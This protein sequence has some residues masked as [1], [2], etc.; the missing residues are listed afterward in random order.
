MTVFIWPRSGGGPVENYAEREA[1]AEKE[2]ERYMGYARE[3]RVPLVLVA[4]PRVARLYVSS[5]HL[6]TFT[7]NEEMLRL[8]VVGE[9]D[10]LFQNDVL[11]CLGLFLRLRL[12]AT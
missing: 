6:G 4:I 8:I 3:F 11:C 2:I 5:L 1:M 10:T 9:N 12:T 7:T